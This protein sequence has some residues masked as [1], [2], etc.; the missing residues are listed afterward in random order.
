MEI[1]LREIPNPN[2]NKI[3]I[4]LLHDVQEDIPEYED[5]VRRIYWEYIADWVNA[6]SKKSWKLYLNKSEIKELEECTDDECR[7]K[8]EGEAKERRNEDYFWHL[9]SLNDDYLDVKFADRLHN[10]RDMNWVTREKAIRKVRETERYFL[11]IAKNRN[12][13]AYELMTIEIKRLKKKFEF[14]WEK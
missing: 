2:L 6:L 14:N 4:A 3:I 11:D 9:D 10:L 7:K 8:I 1:L 13:K 12:P 5:V